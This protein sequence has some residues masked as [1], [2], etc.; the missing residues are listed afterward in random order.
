[1]ICNDPELAAGVSLF[2]VPVMP[3]ILICSPLEIN[4]IFQTFTTDEIGCV[5][6]LHPLIFLF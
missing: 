3:K 2:V 6:I 1:M 5:S 4:Q